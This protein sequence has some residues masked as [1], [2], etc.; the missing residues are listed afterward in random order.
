MRAVGVNEFGGPEALEVL[1][2][3]DP[4]PGTG[5]VRIKVAAAAVNPTD[6]GVRSGRYGE[7]LEPFGPPWIPGMD[8]AGTIDTVGPE[9]EGFENGDEVMA[10]VSPMREGGGAYASEV[11]VDVASV[12]K[13]P[14]TVSLQQAAT[15]PMNGLTAW[16][17]LDA[18]DLD[19]GDRL[20]VTGGAG[21]L[22]SYVIQ[23][24]KQNAI[25]VYADASEEDRELVEGFGADIVLDREQD[26]ADQV[27]ELSPDGVDGVVDTALLHA[28]IVPAA[29]DGGGIAAVRAFE[30]E[31]DRDVTVHQISVFDHLDRTDQLEYLANLA[32]NG[33]LQLRVADTYTPQH[34]GEAHERLAEGGVRGRL[35]IEF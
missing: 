22:A 20:L 21:L 7:R 8:L 14:D 23:L 34:A 10:V 27:R 33:H 6:T 17:A 19:F 16:L 11:V 30:G 9:V 29:K 13:V 2:L 24:A 1:E 4:E 28:A 35:L 18:L 25:R 26:L 31:V 12:V 5:Q 15:L 32:G 3:D